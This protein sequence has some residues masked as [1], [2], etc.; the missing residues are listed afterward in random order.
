MAENR[1]IG[2]INDYFQEILNSFHDAEQLLYFASN[3]GLARDPQVISRYNELISPYTDFSEML[4]N[5]NNSHDLMLFAQRNNL[6]EDLQVKNRHHQLNSQLISPYNDF[7][8]M[9]QNY[10]KPQDLLLFAYRNNLIQDP[11]IQNRLQQLQTHLHCG[12]CFR[13]FNDG[14]LK[15]YIKAI[16]K[17]MLHIQFKQPLSRVFQLLKSTNRCT[18]NVIIVMFVE[19]LTPLALGGI[20]IN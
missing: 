5:F 11:Q 20:H 8:E 15:N 10:N 12:K 7:A 4:Q 16:A 17:V 14:N 9:L 6:T 2:L 18:P 19:N 3:N 1:D 13:Q